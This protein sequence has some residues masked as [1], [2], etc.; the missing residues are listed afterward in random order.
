MIQKIFAC[1]GVD[2][3]PHRAHASCEKVTIV[4]MCSIQAIF[5]LVDN[6]LSNLH[7]LP[8]EELATLT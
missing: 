3:N 2:M 6:M 1:A 8:S 5:S 7:T 4:H